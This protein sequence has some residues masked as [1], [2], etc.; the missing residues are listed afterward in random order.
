[1]ETMLIHQCLIYRVQ[2]DWQPSEI[3]TLLIFWLRSI[4]NIVIVKENQ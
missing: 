4:S 1:M 2:H 3:A